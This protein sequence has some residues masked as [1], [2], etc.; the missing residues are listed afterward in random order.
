[1]NRR[2][3]L[4][5]ASLVSCFPGCATPQSQGPGMIV[6]FTSL[7]D[8]RVIDIE[9][10][11]LPNGKAFNGVGLSIH[12]SRRSNWRASGATEGAVP[13]SREL[14]EWVEFTWRERSYPSLEPKNFASQEE[15]SKALAE[16]FRNSPMKVERIFVC[17]RIPQDVVGEA[18]EAKRRRQPHE[19]PDKMLYVYFIWT[20]TGV[21][22]RWELGRG[23]VTLR[24][25][26]D[27]I[28]N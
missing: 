22:F 1:M 20:E 11:R 2:T 13:D 15:Y 24:E 23:G 5:F 21:K 9:G 6:T 16:K 17:S 8:G 3:F 7:I 25:G 28:G 12:G 27:E 4:M 10:A 26:G 19:L 18:I 14:P